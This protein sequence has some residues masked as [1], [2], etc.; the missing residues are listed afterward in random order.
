MPNLRLTM[1]SY[2]EPTFSALTQDK[3]FS[4]DDLN[5]LK[6]A[7]QNTEGSKIDESFEA[8]TL[9]ALTQQ[10]ALDSDKLLSFDSVQV[11]QNKSLGQAIVEIS[12][13]GESAPSFNVAQTESSELS[14]GDLEWLAATEFKRMMKQPVSEDDMKRYAALSRNYVISVAAQGAPSRSEMEWVNSVQR[15]A[16]AGKA[17]SQSDSL[18]YIN[19]IARQN[20]HL[21]DL[22]N[23]TPEP[24]APPTQAD[25]EWAVQLQAKIKTG[26]QPTDEEYMRIFQLKKAQEKFRP[27]PQTQ[28]P[29]VG[30]KKQ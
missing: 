6:Q 26:Y 25:I 13:V 21:N 15:D 14:Q 17:P 18:R 24:T 11:T 7:A 12:L 22:R 4:Q 29:P 23:R 28:S 8:K 30:G 2:L 19:L 20:V 3:S 5:A 10:L 27:Q 9:D 1:P 16:Q